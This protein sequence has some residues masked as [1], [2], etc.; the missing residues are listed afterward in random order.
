MTPSFASAHYSLGWTMSHDGT[1]S[2]E[3]IELARTARRLS[4][5][6][7]LRYAFD[8]LEADLSYFAGDVDRAR[9]LALD[10]AHHPGAHHHARAIAAWLLHATEAHDEARR[11]A[12]EVRRERP[13][14]G[15]SDY[16][17]AIPVSGIKRRTVE[18]H[19]RA[20]GF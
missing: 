16:C 15:F 20:L 7:P 19:F 14:Y 10:A 18:R 5:L 13:G 8:L 1:P 6:D 11:L 9:S 12:G 2:Q 3:G 4:P 17:A